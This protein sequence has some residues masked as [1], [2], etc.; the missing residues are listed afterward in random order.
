MH[1]VR[2]TVGQ[3]DDANSRSY[4]VAVRSANNNNNNNNKQMPIY[5]TQS[6]ETTKSHYSL[7]VKSSEV[8]LIMLAYCCC[9]CQ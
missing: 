3:Q 1:S 4:C 7:K 9:T 6:R 5:V 8:Y 2:Q